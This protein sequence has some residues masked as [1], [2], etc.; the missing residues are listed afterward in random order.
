MTEEK[1]EELKLKVDKDLLINK[2][3]VLI[4]S[5]QVPKLYS[6]YLNH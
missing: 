1:F 4:K 5:I 2:D 3:N 6:F